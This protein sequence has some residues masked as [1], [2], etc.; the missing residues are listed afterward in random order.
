MCKSISY[1]SNRSR[2]ISTRKQFDLSEKEFL[3]WCR[4]KAYQKVATFVGK[5]NDG[6]VDGHGLEAFLRTPCGVAVDS[7]GNVV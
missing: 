2:A 5:S 4:C 7:E 3:Y 1:V 6:W